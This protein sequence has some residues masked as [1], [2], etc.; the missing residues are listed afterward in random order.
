MRA[1]GTPQSVPLCW[2]PVR[3]VVIRQ[4]VKS[5]IISFLAILI[6]MFFLLYGLMGIEKYGFY[7]SARGDHGRTEGGLSPLFIL[8][9]FASIA[10][11]FIEFKLNKK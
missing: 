9:G 4:K 11:G 2:A 1:T 10:Y 7:L 6:G 5:R 8:I 3:L